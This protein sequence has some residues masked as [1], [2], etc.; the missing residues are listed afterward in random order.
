MNGSGSVAK[1]YNVGL[2]SGIL[3]GNFPERELCCSNTSKAEEEMGLVCGSQE[4][5]R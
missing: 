2:E 5:V 3:T 1:F 4:K